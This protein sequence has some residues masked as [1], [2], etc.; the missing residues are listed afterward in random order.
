MDL[1]RTA[2][3]AKNPADRME[4][5][6]FPDSMALYCNL[7]NPDIFKTDGGDRVEYRVQIKV[8]DTPEW[9]A[10]LKQLTDF[11]NA[12]A[13]DYDQ[14]DD[15]TK[16]SCL[17]KMK[18]KDEK[19][20]YIKIHSKNKDFFQVVDK[21]NQPTPEEPWGGSIVKVCGI[22][23]YYKGFGGGMTVYLHKVMIVENSRDAG[24]NAAPA[25]EYKDP[26]APTAE[27]SGD[28]IPF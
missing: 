8:E 9:E 5:I 21:N 2:L 18:Y 20:Q 12:R 1:R 17:K 19:V 15:A 25:G 28:D 14:D 13:A 16:P 4:P 11:Q 23:E 27:P 24:G 7:Q 26:F 6:V 3:M 22:P 10:V